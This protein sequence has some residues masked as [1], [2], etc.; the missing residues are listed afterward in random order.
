ME[1]RLQALE[2]R[3]HIE[4]LLMRYA[5]ALNTRDADLYVSLFA[6]DGEFEIR[7]GHDEPYLGPLKG[8]DAIRKRWFPDGGSAADA[9]GRRAYGP[10]RHMTTNYEIDVRGDTATVRGYFLELVSNGRNVPAGTKP[11]RIH[12]MGRYE[13][14]LVKL[15]GQWLFKKRLVLADFNTAWA[16]P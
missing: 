9:A 16:P 11:P 15:N 10:M 7:L 1:A 2:D 6:P 8:H 3:V 13:D 14:E 12:S 5:A 4:Q